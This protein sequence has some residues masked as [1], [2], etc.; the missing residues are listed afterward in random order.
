MSNT[1]TTPAAT[2]RAAALSLR[3]LLGT[4]PEPLAQDLV[5]AALSLEH[6]AQLAERIQALLPL[7]TSTLSHAQTS[8]L[9]HAQ[10]QLELALGIQAPS[11]EQLLRRMA[12]HGG[13]F[14][15]ALARAWTLA[16]N[17][18]RER[19]RD[20]F[21]WLLAKYV[22]APDVVEPSFET[23]PCAGES[24]CLGCPCPCHA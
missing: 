21:G 17:G 2:Y 7:K 5:G 22:Q 15:Q 8:T 14:A 11:E 9:S 10:S 19:L 3:S 24:I 6:A 23:C 4:L 12:A 13:E 18:N 1:L 20:G 16:D